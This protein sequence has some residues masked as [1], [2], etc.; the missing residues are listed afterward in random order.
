MNRNTAAAV[1]LAKMVRKVCSRV[2]PVSPTGMVASTIIQARRSS[3][4]WMLNR[5]S[6][7]PRSILRKKPRMI[8][9]QSARKNHSSA[10]AVAQCRA[11]M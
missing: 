2:M 4:P 5:R 8:L 10:S 11:T 1:G 6:R 3:G 9:T 7:S